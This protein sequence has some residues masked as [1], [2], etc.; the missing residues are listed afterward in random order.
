[1]RKAGARILLGLALLEMY[2]LWSRAD[3]G[4]QDSPSDLCLE[5]VIAY[6]DDRGRGNLLG[7]QPFM[8][9]ADY[10][11]EERFLLKL[12]GYLEAARREGWLN[13]R[14]IVVFPEYLGTWLVVAG[15]KEQIYRA[16]SIA[17]AMR[18]VV[19]S[20]LFSLLPGLWSAQAADRLRYALFRMKA[21]RMAAIYHRVFSRL[22]ARYAV[23]IVAG[24]IV[25]P[26]P[27]VRDG[28]LSAGEGPLYNVSA[29]YRP[30]GTAHA[31]LARKAFPTA[32]EL[33]F[34]ARAPVEELPVFDTPAGRL[35]V[36]VCADSWYPAPYEVL[37]AKGVELITVPSYLSPDGIW[38]RPWKGYS[39]AA[40]PDDVDVADVGR[41]TEGEAWL[42]YAL[43]G[44]I[45]RSGARYG[46]N[47]FLRGRLWDLGADG[48]TI[49][50]SGSTVTEA[51]HVTGAALVNLW[52]S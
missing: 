12:D 39:G 43:A 4:L 18:V 35:G 49:M 31:S 11:S 32:E 21:A 17:G 36:L 7:V 8:F 34:I 33:P 47:V 30:D 6:G 20:N 26:S 29:V 48:H 50:V 2:R 13:E 5:D 41:L 3:R 14:T 15:E 42:K 52:L 44:R 22:A 51:K 24:S 38:Q 1:M 40:A 45:G 16:R 46:I 25:L 28:R 10:A 27:Q 37:R 23:T 9:P 19:L